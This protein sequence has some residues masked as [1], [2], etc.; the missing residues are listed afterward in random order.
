MSKEHHE[1]RNR[2]LD[3]AESLFSDHGFRDV[4][5]RCITK[6]AGVNIASMSLSRY[7]V[8]GIAVNV[9]GLDSP[10]DGNAMA[11]I[12]SVG[13]IKQAKLVHLEC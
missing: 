6:Q 10:L 5:L 3:T 9:A 7:Q 8:G 11:E 1:T 2:I 13:A 4:S 12:R